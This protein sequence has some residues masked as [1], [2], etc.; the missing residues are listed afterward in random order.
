MAGSP[1]SP[2]PPRLSQHRGESIASPIEDR[3]RGQAVL[4]GEPSVGRPGSVDTRTELLIEAL[5]RVKQIIFRELA[6]LPAEKSR[7]WS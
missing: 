1:P 2:A 5:E 4:P 6:I 3:R 7:T